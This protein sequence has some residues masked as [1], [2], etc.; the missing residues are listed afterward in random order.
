[1]PLENLPL[2][3]AILIFGPILGVLVSLGIVRQEPEIVRKQR[4]APAEMVPLEK[5]GSNPIMRLFNS[6]EVRQ[7]EV[8]MN[9]VL[10]SIIEH[11]DT[12]SECSL[13]CTGTCNDCYYSC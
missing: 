1:V 13:H 6:A 9:L 8:K 4:I 5:G 10:R 3:L 12:L 11:I 7:A 2:R